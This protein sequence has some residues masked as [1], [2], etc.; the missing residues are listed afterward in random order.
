MQAAKAC[1]Q[2][3]PE[4]VTTWR[5]HMC[6]L[7]DFA[8]REGQNSSHCIIPQQQLFFFPP[9]FS[10]LKLAQT[11][12]CFRFVPFICRAHPQ[13]TEIQETFQVFQFCLNLKTCQQLVTKHQCIVG[14]VSS[15]EI[16]KTA[17]K[18]CTKI[19]AVFEKT[20]NQMTTLFPYQQMHVLSPTYVYYA[21]LQKPFR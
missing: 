12:K 17:E 13:K 19:Q 21:E 2:L 14:H 15:T 16:R 4:Q 8:Q 6:R 20:Q 18:Y 10:R 9:F 7:Q 3:Q 11:Y 1:F 5:D